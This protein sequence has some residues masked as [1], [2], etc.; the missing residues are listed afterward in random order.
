MIVLVSYSVIFGLVCITFITLPNQRPFNT[1][2]M[3][4]SYISTPTYYNNKV[5]F[6]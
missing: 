1:V 3:G 6:L 2:R 5:P 4:E